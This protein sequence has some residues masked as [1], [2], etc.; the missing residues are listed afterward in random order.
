MNLCVQMIKTE[1]ERSIGEIVL[2]ARLLQ[3]I[4]D[5]CPGIKQCLALAGKGHQAWATAC[6]QLE[7][8]CL[9]V[10]TIW[11]KVFVKELQI[12]AEIAAKE[13]LRP[14]IALTVN[15]LYIQRWAKLI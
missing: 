14:E 4:P 2:V 15:V 3:S 7:A 12:K 9:E 8:K 11:C 13:A 10:W 5:L 1:E 6:A